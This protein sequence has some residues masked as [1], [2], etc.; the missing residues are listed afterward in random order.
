MKI[1]FIYTG[2]LR[3]WEHCKDNH[4]KNLYRDNNYNTI[5]HTYEKTTGDNTIQIPAEF[6]KG[7]TDH[8]YNTRKRP[9]ATVAQ[10]LNQW[11]NNF[12][13]FCITPKVYDIYVRVRPDIIVGSINFE[14]YDCT[15]NNIYIPEGNDYGGIND[16]FAFGSYEVM[17]KYYSVYLKYDE[18]WNEGVSFHTETMML[19][20]LDKAGVNIVR[21][22]VTEYILREWDI[23]RLTRETMRP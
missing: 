19:H 16:Q 1:I 4:A 21:L 9:E 11:H 22:P 2:N 17:K 12:V 7:M 8:K 3:T 14:Q 18:L 5:W 13:A 23:E 20:N 10:S 6:Y 15:G